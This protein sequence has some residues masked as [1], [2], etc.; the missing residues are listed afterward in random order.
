MKNVFIEMYRNSQ[1]AFW[2]DAIRSGAVWSVSVPQYDGD[3]S[4]ILETRYQSLIKAIRA[5]TD[6]C[7]GNEQ[8]HVR[9]VYE[10]ED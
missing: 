9:I 6:C 7:D 8:M 2:D 3:T 1:Y 5:A 4:G 10:L